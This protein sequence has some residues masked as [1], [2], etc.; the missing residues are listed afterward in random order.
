MNRKHRA[1]PP[2]DNIDATTLDACAHD[3]FLAQPRSGPPRRAVLAG[4]AALG[5]GALMAGAAPTRATAVQAPSSPPNLNLAG[6]SVVLLGTAAGPVPQWQ[7]NMNSQAVIVDGHTYVVDCGNGVVRQIVNAGIPYQT[8][9]NFFI[10][11]L[12]PDHMFDYL[13]AVVAGRSI[14]VQPGFRQVVNTYGPG[15]A[16][17]LPP[18]QPQTGVT[19][20]NPPLPTPGLVDTHQGLLDADAYWM[21]LIYI[22]GATSTFPKPGLP[23]DI[24]DL[25]IPNDIPTPAG[26]NP[27]DN[28]CPSMQPF[29]VFEDGRVKVSAILVNHPH[30]FPAYAYRFDTDNGSVVFSGDTTHETNGNM[31][32]LAA[33]ADLLVHEAGY[34]LDMIAHFTP[35]PLAKAL[36]SSHTDVTQLGPIPQEAGVKALALTHL[37]SLNPLVAYPP[38]IN[39][40]TW[41][42]PINRQYSGPV[43]VGRDLMRFTLRRGATPTLSQ[44]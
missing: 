8:I 42:T 22:Q 25:V 18:D 32:K 26:A 43:Y 38:A 21:N 40:K 23:S 24:R 14:G 36:L 28:P 44:L 35:P 3:V 9:T 1:H 39:D 37:I 12:H 7:R 31:V 30:V 15:R 5:A 10:T 16:G 41:T 29:T 27:G 17:A 20:V 6:T 2:T 33:G 34:E 4:G 11:H 19:P 13:P